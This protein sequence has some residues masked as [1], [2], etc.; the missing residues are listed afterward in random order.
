ME[1]HKG[2]SRGKYRVDVCVK[3]EPKEKVLGDRMVDA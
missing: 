3:V 2:K 1:A